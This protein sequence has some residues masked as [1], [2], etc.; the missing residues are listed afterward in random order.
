M[1]PPRVKS[2]KPIDLLTTQI[3]TGWRAVVF[4][5]APYLTFITLHY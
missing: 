1:R 4:D 3:N 5:A 2:I